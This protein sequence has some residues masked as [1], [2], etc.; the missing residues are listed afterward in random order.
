MTRGLAVHPDAAVELQEAVDWYDQGGQ[1]RGQAF[2]E[3]YNDTVDR[4]LM[5]PDSGAIV[6]E[7]DGPGPD[8]VEVHGA[9]VPKSSYWVIYYVEHDVVSIV[10]VAHER[11]QP[12]YW[13][14]RL[15]H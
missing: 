2:L 9:K 5:W 4:C 10:A 11:R 12:G 15:P 7:D 3:A 13:S 6:S 14:V 8:Q 1:E